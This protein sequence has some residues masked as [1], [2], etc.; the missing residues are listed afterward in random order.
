M[1]AEQFKT[2]VD[3]AAPGE[4]IVYHRG[5]LMFDRGVGALAGVGGGQF[6]RNEKQK[7]VHGVAAMAWFLYETGVA[8]LVQRKIAE[9]DHEYIAIKRTPPK[10]GGKA[11]SRSLVVASPHALRPMRGML[12]TD[13]DAIMAIVAFEKSLAGGNINGPH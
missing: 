13:D 12:P 3:D 11:K 4:A 6:E 1:T 5:C 7:R 10:S 8:L 2:A 9:H